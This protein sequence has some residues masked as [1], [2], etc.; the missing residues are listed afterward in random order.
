MGSISLRNI[1]D[2]VHRRLKSEAK[3]RGVST[4]EAARQLLDEATRPV[5]KVSEVIAAFVKEKGVEFPD[6]ERSQESIEAAV[7]E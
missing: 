5:E 6:I 3:I 4:E 2:D 1:P 7:F